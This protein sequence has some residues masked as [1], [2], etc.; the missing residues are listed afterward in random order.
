MRENSRGSVPAAV[1]HRDAA[2]PDVRRRLTIYFERELRGDLDRG[3]LKVLLG[4]YSTPFPGSFST[5]RPAPGLAA[6]PRAHRL[7]PRLAAQRTI[8]GVRGVLPNP[9]THKEAMTS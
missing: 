2:H 8:G 9:Q 1:F 5:I 3:D 6:T 7:R 4:E